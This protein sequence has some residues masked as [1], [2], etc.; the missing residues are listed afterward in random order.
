MTIIWR[1]CGPVRVADIV[2]PAVRSRMMAGIS[3]KDTRPE[4][5]VRKLLFARG[6]R[7]QL[8]KKGLPGK[9]DLVFPRYRAVVFIHGCFWHGHGCRLFKWPQSHKMFWRK[10]I[11]G[12]RAVDERNYKALRDNGWRVLTVWECAVKGKARLSHELLVDMI[13]NWLCSCNKTKEIPARKRGVWQKTS[14]G[15]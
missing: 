7:Y 5:L 15:K 14:S 13:E 10:K 11:T 12:N 8:H 1:R 3:G 4:L 9:P 2:N 6:F